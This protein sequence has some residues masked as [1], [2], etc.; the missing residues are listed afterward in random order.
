MSTSIERSPPARAARWRDG[1]YRVR[2]VHADGRAGFAQGAPYDRII[3]TA[4][5][6][7]VQ[8]AWYEQLAEGGLLE[9]PLR[10]GTAGTQLISV[11]QKTRRGFR[12]VRALS[13]GFM[14]LRSGSD[15]NGVA[16]REPYL[17]VADGTRDAC[18]T[19]L[20]LGGSALATLSGRA[21]RRLIAN[22]L[23]TPRKTRLGFR[24]DLGALGLFL[25]LTL[26]KGRRVIGVPCYR[27]GAVGRD[28]RSLAL[29]E[30][31]PDQSQVGVMTSYGG[32]EAERILLAHVREWARRGRPRETDLRITV[33][34]D[35]DR[36]RLGVRWPRVL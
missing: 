30:T 26:P 25:S 16:P 36:P 29:I 20:Q 7:T 15:D 1:G 27:V 28:G 2:V 13:G 17:L 34:Y 32:E 8:H 24:A 33:T 3:L 9:L 12:S 6:D 35:A 4:G 18:E 10:L 19:L 23:G 11:L 5:S 21:K 22:A 14:P 31:R